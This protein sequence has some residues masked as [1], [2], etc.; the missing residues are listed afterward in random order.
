MAKA[1]KNKGGKSRMSVKAVMGE[2]L[3][4]PPKPTPKPK[5]DTTKEIYSALEEPYNHIFSK[6]VETYGNDLKK[7]RDHIQEADGESQQNLQTIIDE[8]DKY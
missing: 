6:A 4:P 1:K 8:I 2:I 7:L 5:G 3:T